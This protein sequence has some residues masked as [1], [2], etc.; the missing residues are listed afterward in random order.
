MKGWL[1]VLILGALVGCGASS[2]CRDLCST[3]VLDCGMCTW[4]DISQCSQGCD[5]ELFRHPVR[6]EAIECYLVA[7]ETCDLAELLVCRQLGDNLADE[8]LSGAD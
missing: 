2:D 7:S 6:D 1:L 5:D 4:N 3:L 8:A